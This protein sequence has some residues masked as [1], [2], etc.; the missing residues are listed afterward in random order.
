MP[1][2]LYP[3][4]ARSPVTYLPDPIN[5]SVTTI[6][7]DNITL[8]PPAPNIATIGDGADSETIKYEGKSGDSLVSVIRGFEGEARS[9]SGGTPI[10][11]VPCAQHVKALQKSIENIHERIFGDYEEW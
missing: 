5:D 3:P 7:V 4:M 10:A 11:N 8:L 1:H 2:G 6:R 9:W